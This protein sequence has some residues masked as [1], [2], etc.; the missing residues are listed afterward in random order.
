[1]DECDPGAPLD[2][3]AEA[4]AHRYDDFP[5]GA[6]VHKL[7]LQILPNDEEHR[8]G[9][10]NPTDF[11]IS[12][13]NI[14]FQA[15]AAKPYETSG[16]TGKPEWDLLFGFIRQSMF[17]STI[18]TSP[19]WTILNLLCNIGLPLQPGGPAV[20]ANRVLPRTFTTLCTSPLA[21]PVVSIWSTPPGQAPLSLRLSVWFSQVSTLCYLT[22]TVCQSRYLRLKICGKKLSVY[23][24]VGFL[25]RFQPAVGLGV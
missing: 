10:D 18:V 20:P 23:S 5:H 3:V 25:V 2:F 24:I 21:K 4:G 17:W 1:M 14:H 8:E 15:A 13:P 22:A 9:F 19:T 11:R 6:F 16:A 7:R 12:D